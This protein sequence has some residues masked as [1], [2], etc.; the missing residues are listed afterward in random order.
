MMVC[1]GAKPPMVASSSTF[2][3]LDFS[4]F[5]I[6]SVKFIDTQKKVV[7]CL[8]QRAVYKLAQV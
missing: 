2:G 1:L 7:L 5:T 6:S 8:Q 4:T 3:L